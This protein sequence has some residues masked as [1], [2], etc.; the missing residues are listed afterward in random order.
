M[1]S[2]GERIVAL[3]AA[4]FITARLLDDSGVDIILVGDSLG[5]TLLGYPSTV[6]VTMRDMLHHLNAVTR[7]H[8]AALVVADMPFASYQQSTAQAVRNAARLA[9]EGGADAVKLEGGVAEAHTIRAIVRT[10]IPVMAHIG[11]L[12]QS[13][14]REGGYRVQGKTPR[15]A[16]VLTRDLQAVTR[17]GAF[18][19]ILE[20]IHASVAAKLTRKSAIPTIGIGSGPGCDGQVLVTSDILG[21]QAWLEPKAARRY[22]ELG[23]AMKKAFLQYAKDVRQG[24]FPGP[25]ESF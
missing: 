1:K 7:A 13:V 14:L 3:T 17:A 12:P 20:Y 4:D 6:S 16:A 25:A 11:L 10:G 19:C 18:A 23:H 9:R 5:T 2:R 8:P 24:T 15:Q 22:A 21:L